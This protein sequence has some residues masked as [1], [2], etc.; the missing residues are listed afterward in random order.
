MPEKCVS[1]SSCGTHAPGWFNGSHPIVPGEVSSGQVCFN[2]IGS[3]CQW[4]TSVRVKNCDWFYIYELPKTPLCDLQYCGDGAKGKN[5]SLAFLWIAL[6]RTKLRCPWSKG[7][8]A[9]ML[10][11]I[12]QKCKR[13]V[14]VQDQELRL[15]PTELPTDWL[16]WLRIGLQCRSLLVRTRAGPTLMQGL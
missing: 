12:F 5:L 8:E 11:L 9:L 2:W 6:C 10:S 13:N 1:S 15:P 16:I 4:S 3:C 14:V 7:I